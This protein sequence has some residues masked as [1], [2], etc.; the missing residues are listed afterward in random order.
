[1]W[2]KFGLAS[3]TASHSPLESSSRWSLKVAMGS[4]PAAAS[5]AASSEGWWGSAAAVTMAPSTWL[6]FWM[7]SMPIIPE[8]MMP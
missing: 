5:T 8:P 2:V 4:S 7:C 6:M 3:T 1:M